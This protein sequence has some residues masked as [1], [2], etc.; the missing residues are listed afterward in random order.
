MTTLSI[1]TFCFRL[2][3]SRELYLTTT[4][5]SKENTT[6]I[7]DIFTSNCCER[8]PISWATARKQQVSGSHI[9]FLKKTRITDICIYPLETMYDFL[10][11]LPAMSINFTI[12][13]NHI[14]LLYFSF[15]FLVQK[16]VQ[17]WCKTSISFNVA[18]TSFF[19]FLV[20]KHI[21]ACALFT[22]WRSHKRCLCWFEGILI[23]L[24]WYTYIASES[25]RTA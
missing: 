5:K 15:F 20:R 23:F 14:V 3:A 7:Y 17:L 11:G 6:L 4:N 9:H 16:D 25:R 19:S 24:E 13:Y 12:I 1:S 8:K 18:S 22:I 2:L 10:W 21:Q